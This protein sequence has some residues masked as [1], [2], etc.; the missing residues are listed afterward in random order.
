MSTSATLLADSAALWN[1]LTRH[2]FVLAAGAGT[3]PAAA[4]DRWLVE[5]YHYVVEF[6]RFLARLAAGAPD[7]A[8]R[9]LL[10]EALVPLRA[11]LE[12]FR[13]Q[14]A[15]RQLDLATDP[16]LT[17]LGYASYLHAA[18]LDGFEVGLT[19]LY[20]AEQAYYD[21]WLAVRASAEAASP[22]WPFIDNWSAPAFGAWVDE[23]AS[24]LDRV[25]PTGPSPAQRRGFARVVRLEL[26][27]WDAVHV[28]EI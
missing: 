2:P 26:R 19:V 22:Y 20:G 27:F 15:A 4:F 17:T 14:A 23:L 7:E 24:A 6:R 5:D 28:G 16:G 21:A 1:S 12:L 25:S 13:G 18:L 10:L 8:I 3:L 11:E 9:N